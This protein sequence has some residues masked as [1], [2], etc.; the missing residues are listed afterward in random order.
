MKLFEK[1]SKEESKNEKQVKKIATIKEKSSNGRKSLA[2]VSCK[3]LS[4]NM[5]KVSLSNKRLTNE[6]DSWSS[7]PLDISK[8]GKVYFQFFSITAL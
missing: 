8:L 1:S 3:G 5:M 2:K 6:S 7:L 4:G